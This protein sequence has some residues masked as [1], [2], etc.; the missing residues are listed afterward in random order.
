MAGR[1]TAILAHDEELAGE[2]CRPEAASDHVGQ[3]AVCDRRRASW[4]A[5]GIFPGSR[6]ACAKETRTSDTVC[7]PGLGRP[8][9][10]TLYPV[11]RSTPFPPWFP[12]F[13]S[14]QYMQRRHANALRIY[15]SRDARFPTRTG[16]IRRRVLAGSSNRPMSELCNQR[17]I[18]LAYAICSLYVPPM[19]MLNLGKANLQR[20]DNLGGTRADKSGEAADLKL[21]ENG[22]TPR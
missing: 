18:R 1:A 17:E 19:D 6:H 22:E 12:S 4:P 10:N 9:R 16:T 5:L 21:P 20:G 2:P 7:G 14:V 13:G 11:S 15:A 8:V 3:F